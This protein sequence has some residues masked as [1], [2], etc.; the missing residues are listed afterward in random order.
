MVPRGPD[1]AVTSL[2]RSCCWPAGEEKEKGETGGIIVTAQ[3][4][5]SI[6][7]PQSHHR[8]L[9]LRTLRTSS[10][11]HGRFPAFP[12]RHRPVHSRYFQLLIPLPP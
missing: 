2:S 4:P 12:R 11:C 8:G 7:C 1:L 10:S 5:W 9:V 6:V 3:G